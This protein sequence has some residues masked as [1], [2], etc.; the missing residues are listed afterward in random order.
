MILDFNNCVEKDFDYLEEKFNHFT[1]KAKE[2][3]QLEGKH[4]V[5]VSIVDDETIKTINRDYRKIDRVTDVI[6]FAF[7][8]EV[9]GEVT[10]KNSEINF[11][12]EIYINYQRATIQAE[13]LK[14]SFDREMC[15]L[16]V[17]GLLHL[18]GYDH[19]TLEEEQEMLALQRKLFEGEIL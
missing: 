17:H 4:F 3:L 8:D 16:F 13:D 14:Q 19:M 10:I 11:L 5:E 18:L 1:A 12:G 7:N 15:F 9:E 6:S 2:M